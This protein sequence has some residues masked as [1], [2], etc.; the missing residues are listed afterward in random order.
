MQALTE[1]PALLAFKFDQP[2]RNTILVEKIVELMSLA[3]IPQRDNAQSGELTVAH[4]PP[5]AHDQ[6]INYRA[7]HTRQFSERAPDLDRRDF[8]NFGFF[9]LHARGGQRGGAL[10]HRDVPDKVTLLSSGEN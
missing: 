2:M 7:A 1:R 8:Q 4:Q 10:Q 9:R 3:R 5:P 6:S